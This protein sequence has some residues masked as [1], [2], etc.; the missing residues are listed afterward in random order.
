MQTKKASMKEALT[1]VMVGLGISM[2]ANAFIFPLV[3]G[4]PVKF[5]DNLII[6]LFMTVISITRS[7]CIRRYN[8]RKEARKHESIEMQLST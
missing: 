1:N 6:G 7:Y 4:V 3:L 2:T 5:M 8:N